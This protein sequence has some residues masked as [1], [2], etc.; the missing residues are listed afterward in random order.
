MERPSTQH[1]ETQ[2]LPWGL[3]AVV[4]VWL[5][6]LVLAY[7]SRVLL[8]LYT[9]LSPLRFIGAAIIPGIRSSIFAPGTLVAAALLVPIVIATVIAFRMVAGRYQGA[10]LQALAFTR[11]NPV[12]VLA[13]VVLF[14]VLLTFLLR[15]ALGWSNYPLP[16]LEPPAGFLSRVD[17]AM[18]AVSVP[19]S[20]LLVGVLVFGFCYPVLVARLGVWIGGL[21]CAVFFA[22]PQLAIHGVYWQPAVALFVMGVYF[23]AIR[24]RTG[25]AYSATLGYTGFAI[26]IAL[27]AALAELA[28]WS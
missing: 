4:A 20:A 5:I 10:P 15:I 11:L 13:V 3:R 2:N 8:D 28:V 21:L 27:S 23:T 6:W 25:S 22:L 26:Y 12:W 9:A 1:S 24:E 17:L 14:S 18:Y 16:L 7:A 19:L